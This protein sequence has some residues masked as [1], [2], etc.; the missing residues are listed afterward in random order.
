MELTTKQF[1][2]LILRQGF[3]FVEVAELM[4][5]KTDSGL[6]IKAISDD[7]RA[8]FFVRKGKV[9]RFH[10]DTDYPPFNFFY[11]SPLDIEEG[12]EVWWSANVIA[13]LINTDATEPKVFTHEGKNYVLVPYKSLTMRKR[14]NEYVGLNDF[15]I[16][17]P[18]KREV[19]SSLDVSMTELAK[20]LR[21]ILEV[22]Y[23]PLEGVKYKF[24]GRAVKVKAGDKIFLRNDG[25]MINELES[26]YVKSM[27]EVLY[28]VQS[29]NIMAV[30]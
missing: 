10:H 4:K 24:G 7:T 9:V 27:D 26:P 30:E 8:S 14:G 23:T 15:V 6:T 1:K 11:D 12:D 2:T 16:C 19:K 13:N 22:V 20:P 21:R 28:T 29:D 18:I 17:R 3:V 5:E 25:Q